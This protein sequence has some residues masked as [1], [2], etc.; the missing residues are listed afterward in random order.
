ME[1]KFLRVQIMP[2]DS[3]LATP[4]ENWC[5]YRGN[6]G[7]GV[8]FQKEHLVIFFNPLQLEIQSTVIKLQLLW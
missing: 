7:G 5:R 6:G 1:C 8:A 3:G 4:Y 2:T